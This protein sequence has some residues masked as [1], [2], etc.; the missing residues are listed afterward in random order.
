ME[1]SDWDL[2]RESRLGHPQA[3][4]ELFE[5][6]HR[7]V[8]AVAVGMT[9]NSD[10]AKDVAQEAFLRAHRSLESFHGESSFYTWLYRIAVNVAIDFRRRDS[11]RAEVIQSGLVV[12][13]A[14]VPQE[15][16][17]PSAE[18]ARKQIGERIFAVIDEL[19]PEHKAAILLREIEGLSYEDI[20]KVMQ[21]SKGTVMS[22]L[23]YARKKLQAKLRDLL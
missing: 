8:L 12:E 4:R 20:S 23:H 11:R 14:A 19:T 16:L 13:E 22:R 15:T 21:C 10:D 18:L 9:G 3:F 5:R 6:Y 1:Q 17:E 2:V 7:Q